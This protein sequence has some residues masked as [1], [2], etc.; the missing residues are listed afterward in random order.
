MPVRCFRSRR[1]RGATLVEGAFVLSLALLLT[2]GVIILALG[3]Y[4]YNQVASLARRAAR[5]ATVHGGEF[6]L[7]TGQAMATP[8]SIYDNVIQPAAIGMDTNQ[9]TYSITWDNPNE[10]PIY[11]ANPTTGQYLR[12]RVSVTIS[13]NWVPEAYLSGI[14]LTST[15]VME[16]SY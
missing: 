14:T 15:S 3:V 1:R 16:M 13:Y 12:N 4:R 11:M 8:Q 2:L 10:M 9:L 7:D 5:Y 6:A